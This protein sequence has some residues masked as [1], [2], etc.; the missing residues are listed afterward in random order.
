MNFRFDPD[1]PND[2][3]RVLRARGPGSTTTSPSREDQRP[4]QQPKR[5]LLVTAGSPSVGTNRKEPRV[6]PLIEAE[7]SANGLERS[8]PSQSLDLTLPPG[9]AV[10]I[11]GPNGAGKTTFVRMVATLL[12]PDSGS[13]QVVGH[14]VRRQS[15]AVR[16]L[17]GLAGQSAAVEEMMS[18][19]E[20]LVMVARLYG[21]T[22]SQARSS[23]TRIL[24]RGQPGGRGRPPGPHLFRRH[25][26][27]AGSRGQPGRLAPPV[28]LDEPTT[29]LD[30]GSRNEVWDS[31]RA[32]GHAGTDIVL[33]TQYLDEA[34][35]L[36]APSSSSTRGGSSPRALRTS[37]SRG[38]APISSNST[39]STSPP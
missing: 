32:M 4:G 23:A 10:A 17:I 11:L 7:A 3:G 18:G 22:A 25:A 24:A 20:N 12:H 21:Q 16:R 33:T 29:G 31:I 39:P 27:P 15:M 1:R 14:D 8:R 26:P 19:R 6:P 34:D 35:H 30:P 2:P 13:L 28:L 9:Q 37:S 38:W 5:S 36:A